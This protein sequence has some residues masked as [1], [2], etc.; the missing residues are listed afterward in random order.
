MPNDDLGAAPSPRK[1]V[2][3]GVPRRATVPQI[4]NA[5]EWTFGTRGLKGTR[6]EDIAKVC[7]IPKANILYYFG[8]KEDLYNATLARLLDVWLTDADTWLSPD[9][10]PIEGLKGYVEAKIAFSRTRPEGSRL[11]AQELLSGGLMVQ[12]FLRGELRAHVARHVAIFLDWQARG[13]M[14]PIDPTHF[15]LLLWS[16]TQSYADMQVQ[17]EAIL[18]RAPLTDADYDTG[19]ATIMTLVGSLFRPLTSGVSEEDGKPVQRKSL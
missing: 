13:I 16:G 19:V 17:Y 11:F 12:E 18:D 5:A 8:S 4:L 14:A 2:R 1:R 6:L 7:D 3:A 15:L 10:D 9:R